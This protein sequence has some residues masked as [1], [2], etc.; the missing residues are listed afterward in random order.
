MLQVHHTGGVERTSHTMASAFSPRPPLSKVSGHRTPTALLP[1]HECRNAESCEM[2]RSGPQNEVSSFACTIFARIFSTSSCSTTFRCAAARSR[3]RADAVQTTK[4]GRRRPLFPFTPRSTTTSPYPTAPQAPPANTPSM[5]SSH[6]CIIRAS[7][8]THSITQRPAYVHAMN[9]HGP[10]PAKKTAKIPP[11]PDLGRP[12][13][14]QVV[15]RWALLARPCRSPDWSQPDSL[16][17]QYA[18]PSMPC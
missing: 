6:S 3:R 1:L 2:A 17:C 11:G 5:H 13:C 15:R 9:R 7:G 8:S 16:R 12:I 18:M 10:M 14:W 4:I